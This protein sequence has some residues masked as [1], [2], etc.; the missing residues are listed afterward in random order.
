MSVVKWK[1]KNLN[2]LNPSP[3]DLR[4]MYVYREYYN[5]KR[6]SLVYPGSKSND[7]KGAYLPTPTYENFDKE[8]S[9]IL[10][11]VPNKRIENKSLVKTWQCEIK[12][13]FEAWIK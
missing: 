7:I 8:C 11:S 10:L 5:A 4:E 9:I 2:G 12:A 1:W 3:E 13:K 6:V